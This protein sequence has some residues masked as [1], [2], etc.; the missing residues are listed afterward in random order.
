MNR[1]P[2]TEEEVT[3]IAVDYFNNWYS[4]V[5]VGEINLV[6]TRESFMADI[7]CKSR[8]KR[9]ARVVE[10][11]G[12]DPISIRNGIAQAYCF[13]VMYD[14]EGSLVADFDDRLIDVA[15]TLPIGV[16]D[17]NSENKVEQV[18]KCK[19]N[20]I[21]IKPDRNK[22]KLKDEIR[23][24]EGK[25]ERLESNINDYVSKISELENEVTNARGT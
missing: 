4:E 8:D 3:D 24:L 19:D 13:T 23:E 22:G 14:R 12:S 7:V 9:V 6:P 1:A 21:G 2:L 18:S 25:V 16:F 20:E 10:C 15:R 11:K 17:I 5:E